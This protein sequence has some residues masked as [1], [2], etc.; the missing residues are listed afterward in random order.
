MKWLSNLFALIIILAVHPTEAASFDCNKART[1]VEHL[2]CSDQELSS[3]D[4]ILASLYKAGV[5]KTHADPNLVRAQRQWLAERDACSVDPVKMRDCVMES[6]LG[7]GD[8]LNRYG[9]HPNIRPF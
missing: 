2:I 7:R 8:A 5:S 3:D 1:P 9:S 4:D 6:Y